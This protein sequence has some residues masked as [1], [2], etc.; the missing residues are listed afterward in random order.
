VSIATGA[1]EMLLAAG[2]GSRVIATVEF[3][4]RAGP[5]RQKFRASAIAN[6][7]DSWSAWSACQT[8]TSSWSGEGGSNVAQVN[9]LE[10][11]KRAAVF[12]TSGEASG[13]ILRSSLR[14]LGAR[15]S[16]TRDIAEKAD[17][18]CGTTR[19]RARLEQRFGQSATKPTVLLEVWNR[20]S[21]PVGG[22]H[23]MTDSLRSVRRAECVRRPEEQGPSVDTEAVIGTRP[24]DHRGGGAAGRGGRVAGRM[25]ALR[26]DARRARRQARALRRPA[27]LALGPVPLARHEALCEALNRK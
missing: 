21:T 7:F 12:G 17:P 27:T 20:P 16:T 2:A 25:E 26:N 24:A 4:R 15:S 5:K 8:K 14:R 22:S 13:D 10:R 18:G 6:A 23:M 19:P 3:S 1:T 9:R 11:L